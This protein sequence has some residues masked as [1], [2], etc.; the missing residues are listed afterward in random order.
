VEGLKREISA[1]DSDDDGIPDSW[2]QSHGLDIKNPH[3]NITAMPSGYSAIE[4]Y[5]NELAARKVQ[6]ATSRQR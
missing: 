3:D 6:Q 4:E 2:E 5:I 1:R